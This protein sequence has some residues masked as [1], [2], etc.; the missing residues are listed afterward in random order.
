[1]KTEIRLWK[2]GDAGGYNLV[3]RDNN[4]TE[5][6]KLVLSSGQPWNCA[7]REAE[8]LAVVLDCELYNNDVLVRE[9]TS[10]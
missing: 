5:T 3:V 4:I 2:L 9:G 10:V 7:Y 8:L 1:M 6:L